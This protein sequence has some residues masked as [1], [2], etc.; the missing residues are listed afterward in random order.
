MHEKNVIQTGADPSSARGAMIMLHGRGA[1][2]H[3]ILSL[4]SHLEVK[5]FT[6]LAPQA[7]NN[8]WYPYSFLAPVAENEPWLSSAL[9]LV[10]L[11]VEKLL[12]DGLKHQ[13]IYFTGFSQGA[14]LTLEYITRNA[15][16]WG[17]AI[18]FT[19][20]LIG[21]TLNQENYTGDFSGTPVYIGTSD[22]DPH[23]P[24]QRVHETV[25]L[26]KELQANVHEDI[27]PNMGHTIIPSEITHANDHVLKT[28]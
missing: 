23:V 28:S 10:N 17:G 15:Q 19:G 1:D 24:V 25:N 27:F 14:C 16:R 9:E 21:K 7:T 3:D 4:A 13:Q 26:M 2:A 22:P 12:A 5:D 11:C 18:A 6:L 8:T 20:G